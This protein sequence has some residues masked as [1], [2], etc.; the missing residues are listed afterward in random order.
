VF[1]EYG[2]QLV[3]TGHDHVWERLA[4]TNGT[5]F[6][7]TGGGG[8]I[9]YEASRREPSSARIMPL[10]HIVRAKLRGD[11]LSLE[12][13]EPSGRVIDQFSIRKE[14]KGEA[15]LD[16]AWH[17]PEFA[18][19]DADNAD[20]NRPGERF[21]MPGAGFVSV[22]GR[23]ANP[24]ELRVNNDLDHIHIGL[25]DVMLWPGQT[26]ALFV[27]SPRAAGVE[28]LARAGSARL[29]ALSTLRLR[30]C[31]FRPRMVCLL[32][33]EMADSTDPGFS[34]PGTGL[35]MGQGV[36]LLDPDLTPAEDARLTQFNRSPEGDPDPAEQNADFIMV[37]LPRSHL[38][39][40]APGDSIQL[41]AVVVTPRENGLDLDTAYLGRS[42]AFENPGFCLEPVTVK[43]A[44]PP[45]QVRAVRDRGSLVLTW[46]ATI[47]SKYDIETTEEVIT[48][49]AS[50]GLQGFPRVATSIQQEVR[51]GLDSEQRATRWF[52]IRKLP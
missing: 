7:V 6:V 8:G 16:A 19:P 1:A 12:A 10:A 25:R 45:L 47:G 20:G 43:L 27:G 13:I 22:A 51:L 44:T 26:L 30:F 5:H 52:R 34:R 38:G 23:S 42:L 31:E 24:G 48:G 15:R 17:T 14:V 39:G 4:P 33:D 46:L 32:G 50:A 29:H 28:D 11:V 18:E 2:V 3:L 21:D 41:G 36:F 9:I 37:S 49:F 40:V 35:S